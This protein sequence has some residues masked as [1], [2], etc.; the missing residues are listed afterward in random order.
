MVG[1]VRN[2]LDPATERFDQ[3]VLKEPVRVR[4]HLLKLLFVAWL[5]GSVLAYSQERTNVA[6]IDSIKSEKENI[7]EKAAA[8]LVQDRN[9]LIRTLI[10][11]IEGDWSS[12]IK[13]QA[14]DVLGACRTSEA[15][16]VLIKNLS[17]EENRPSSFGLVSEEELYRKVRPICA[18]LKNIGDPA[19]P[20]LVERIKQSAAR[21]TFEKCVVIC[22][23]IEGREQSGERFRRAALSETDMERKQRLEAGVKL[24]N[25]ADLPW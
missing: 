10:G 17:L 16:P 23:K 9:E 19:I 24:V 13:V 4:F 5:C 14:A 11:I 2:N 18:A 1:D 3:S 8:R 15:V 25:T 22:I 21:R 6:V 20:K 7:R 12:E